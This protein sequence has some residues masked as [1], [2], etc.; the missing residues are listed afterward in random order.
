MSMELICFTVKVVSYFVS[1]VFAGGC[2]VQLGLELYLPLQHIFLL[3]MPC[4]LMYE[5]FRL[6]AINVHN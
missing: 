6:I 5:Y 2:C 1:P 3:D 4:F